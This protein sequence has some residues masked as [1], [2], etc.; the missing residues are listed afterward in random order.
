MSGLFDPALQYADAVLELASFEV[1]DNQRDALF[2]TYAQ[3]HPLR[4]GYERRLCY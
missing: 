2:A 1:F 3:H 4:P